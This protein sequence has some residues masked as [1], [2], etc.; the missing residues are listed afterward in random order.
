MI[1]LI[2]NLHKIPDDMSNEVAVFSEPLASTCRVFE[3][4]LVCFKYNDEKRQ[5]A[6]GGD[7]V[8]IVG[9]GKL[10]LCVAEICGRECLRCT[11]DEEGGTAATTKTKPSAPVLIGKHQHNLFM[12]KVNDEGSVGDGG[13]NLN[14]FRLE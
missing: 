11:M 12:N 9:D 4:G 5:M 10:G 14:V 8:P 2:T 13:V 1:L 3:K 6:R 7:H